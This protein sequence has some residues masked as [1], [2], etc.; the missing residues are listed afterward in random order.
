VV[1]NRIVVLSAH[2]IGSA[3]GVEHR[4]G[5]TTTLDV[6]EHGMTVRLGINLLRIDP[7][8]ARTVHV[9]YATGELSA[10]ATPTITLTLSDPAQLESERADRRISQPAARACLSN[11]RTR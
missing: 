9:R 8:S 11:D 7:V 5:T 3:D 2:V 10:S 1:G 6:D 4:A